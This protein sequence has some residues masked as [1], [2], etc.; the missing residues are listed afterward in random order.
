MSPCPSADPADYEDIP[1]PERPANAGI[2]PEVPVDNMTMEMA[3]TISD[4]PFIHEDGLIIRAMAILGRRVRSL[5][6]HVAREQEALDHAHANPDGN[7]IDWERMV[8]LAADITTAAR[9]GRAAAYR[10]K[11]H[12]LHTKEEIRFVIDGPPGHHSGRFVEVEDENG[13]SIRVGE[14]H[15]RG[16]GLWEL[17]VSKSTLSGS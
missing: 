13:A 3:L 2:E 9:S 6:K 5:E 10:V 1:A 4:N 15:A 17:R 16:D 7:Q 11:H 12:G 8:G 14:W